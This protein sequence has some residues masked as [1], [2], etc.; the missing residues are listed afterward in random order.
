MTTLQTAA[1]TTALL[2]L[3]TVTLSAGSVFAELSNS[4]PTAKSTDEI[5][6]N[7]GLDDHCVTAAASP[8]RNLFDPDEIAAAYLFENPDV[9]FW[10]TRNSNIDGSLCVV[11]IET[12]SAPEDA[13]TLPESNGSDDTLIIQTVI[14]GGGDFVGDGSVYKLNNLQISSPT[15]IWNMPSSP[16]INARKIAQIRSPDVHI[17][18]SLING[19][20]QHG[21]HSGWELKDGAHRFI[22]VNSGVININNSNQAHAYAVHGAEV[23]D[24]HVACNRF[25][26]IISANSPVRVLWMSAGNTGSKIVRGGVFANNTGGNIQSGNWAR[27]ADV[28]VLQ[29]HLGNQIQDRP[30]LIMA[31]RFINGGK[32]FVKWQ[33]GN[34][35]A[36]SNFYHWRDAIGPLGRR[37][38]S[39]AISSFTSNNV[40]RNNHLKYSANGGVPKT[41]FMMIGGSIEKNPHNNHFNNNTIEYET[42]PP[43]TASSTVLV[44]KHVGPNAS[45][46]FEFANSTFTNNTISGSGRPWHN[47]WFREGWNTE[48]AAFIHEPNSWE[49]SG[50]YGFYRR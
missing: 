29:S 34:S 50:S 18:N 42:N 43:A 45:T 13:T 5:T 22:L 33:T 25:E 20:N 8:N 23:D 3:S 27:D 19:N 39:E 37:S 38:M 49:S 1:R 44:A 2:F 35:K 14:Q 46:G 16:A 31:N 9:C 11:P 24:I 41:M 17:Y 47:F 30:F 7:I 6:T 12:P 28:V 10:E 4:D 26:N 48:G 36:L 32:R 40:A 21:F 15:R